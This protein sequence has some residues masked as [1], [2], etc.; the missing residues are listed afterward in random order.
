M[1]TVRRPT[2]F[3]RSLEMATQTGIG[4]SVVATSRKFRTKTFSKQYRVFGH[5]GQE[6]RYRLSGTVFRQLRRRPGHATCVTAVRSVQDLQYGVRWYSRRR[7]LSPSDRSAGASG[8]R[9]GSS[10]STISSCISSATDANVTLGPQKLPIEAVPAQP[11]QGYL[12][13]VRAVTCGGAS[14]TMIVT[15][16]RRAVF[17]RPACTGISPTATWPWTPILLI[18]PMTTSRCAQCTRPGMSH[19]SRGDRLRPDVF[20][21]DRRPRCLHAGPAQPIML[22]AKRLSWPRR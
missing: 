5:W 20:E 16:S 11:D 3:L 13:V 6:R 2:T 8:R 15:V 21:R 17:R 18:S 12:T 9:S 14:K 4:I 10:M 7:V 19:Q 22:R 1:T